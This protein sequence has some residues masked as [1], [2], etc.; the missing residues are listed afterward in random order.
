[1]QNH[2]PAKH[3]FARISRFAPIVGNLVQGPTSR[4]LQLA[5]D[6][7]YDTNRFFTLP[8]SAF[9]ISKIF[10][11]EKRERKCVRIFALRWGRVQNF[12]DFYRNSNTYFSSSFR[13]P[14]EWCLFG[15]VS[16][17]FLRVTNFRK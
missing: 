6:R 4:R 11:F 10:F 12:F 16:K 17:I 1:M 5:N 3:L 15:P 9:V 2:A 13:A 8:K 7:V 14:H